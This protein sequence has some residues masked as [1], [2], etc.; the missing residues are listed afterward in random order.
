MEVTT[1]LYF[2]YE[3][4]KAI[5]IL[6]DADSKVSGMADRLVAISKLL[7]KAASMT[8]SVSKDEAAHAS[9]DEP[10]EVD[11]VSSLLMRLAYSRVTVE[12]SQLRS[13]LVDAEWPLLVGN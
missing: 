3:L 12:P 11:R 5:S 6:A 10:H 7:P 13:A 1:G 2:A 8:S 9:I 4:V